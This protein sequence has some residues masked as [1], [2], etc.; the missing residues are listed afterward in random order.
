MGYER[1]DKAIFTNKKG[2]K[3]MKKYILELLSKGLSDN[4]IAK[5]C[6]DHA[7]AKELDSKGILALL[8][9]AKKEAQLDAD[10]NDREKKEFEDK[11]KADAKAEA[12]TLVKEELK[13]IGFDKFSKPEKDLK[14]YN[15]ANGSYE[16]RS[17]RDQECYD[18]F[19][20]ML[21][22]MMVGNELSAQA[23]SN[24]IDQENKNIAIQSKTA[25]V[26][27]TDNVG[28]YAVPTPVDTQIHELIYKKSVVMQ[29]FNTDVIMENDKIY[30]VMANAEINWIAT[31]DTAAT[32]TT[33]AFTAPT[34]NMYRAGAFSAISNKLIGASVGDIVSSFIRSYTSAF[35]RFTDQ[36]IFQGNIT[37]HSDL[38]DGL[39]WNASTG[40]QTAIA[41]SA[42]GVDDV[43]TLLE[44]VSD[45]AGTIKLFGNKK[46]MFQLGLDENTGGMNY[47]PTFVSGGSFAPFGTE[48]VE[49][50]KITN[51]LDVGG[52]DS[53]GGTDTALLA[54]DVDN[55][56]V[57]LG[58]STRIELSKDFLFTKDQVVIRGV[59][60]LGYAVLH[61][62]GASVQMLELTGAS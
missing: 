59:K 7:E 52:D 23:V 22:F 1:L 55:V 14:V 15:Y 36:Q 58:K 21:K 61:A 54:V 57:G 12:K 53:T 19:G 40:V 18:Q 27:G 46:V 48:Y 56:V 25:N 37:G 6:L 9:E 49:N 17:D 5:K 20:K 44:A 32:Q 43:Q 62:S 51:V 10:L 13:S 28:G 35:G 26:A 30:P 45:E 33:P 24:E 29:N 42:L 2:E 3:K 50:T 41:L 31:E 4:E 16:E 39:I 38:L 11:V 8:D 34:A 47:F 60:D